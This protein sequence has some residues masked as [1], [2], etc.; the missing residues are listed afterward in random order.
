MMEM[1]IAVHYLRSSVYSGVGHESS[2]H[3]LQLDHDYGVTIVSRP[4]QSSK[5]ANL[6]SVSSKLQTLNSVQ[7]VVTISMSLTCTLITLLSNGIYYHKP[8]R[9]YNLCG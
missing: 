2:S 1:I 9:Q 3:M 5:T 4:R 7:T 8:H 6:Q